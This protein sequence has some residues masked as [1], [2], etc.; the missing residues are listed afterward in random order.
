MRNQTFGVP[1]GIPPGSNGSPG[2][3]QAPHRTGSAGAGPSASCMWRLARTH[4]QRSP[5][6]AEGRDQVSGGQRSPVPPSAPSFLTRRNTM[7][8]HISCHSRPLNWQSLGPPTGQCCSWHPWRY[9]GNEKQLL[10]I[11][12]AWPGIA[13]E[14][15]QRIS[16]ARRTLGVGEFL[17]LDAWGWAGG[18][19]PSCPFHLLKQ[20]P[21]VDRSETFCLA[22][23]PRPGLVTA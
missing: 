19:H 18:N 8:F 3:H 16:K 7:F 13:G 22:K 15:S 1:L 20:T 9:R 14:S 2:S 6:R 10:G 12:K 5:G 4:A 11:K 17:P 21:Q 23:C